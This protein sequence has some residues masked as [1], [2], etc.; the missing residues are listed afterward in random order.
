MAAGDYQLELQPID[1]AGNTGGFLTAD[2]IIKQAEI[3][4]VEIDVIL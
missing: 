1:L 3:S 4:K 2:L